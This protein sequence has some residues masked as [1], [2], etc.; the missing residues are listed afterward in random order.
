MVESNV[1][2]LS[3]GWS[4]GAGC[5]EVVGGGALGEGRRQS[6]LGLI[7]KRAVAMETA[8]IVVQSRWLL[9]SG[10]CSHEQVRQYPVTVGD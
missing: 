5:G 10:S 4:G 7:L 2:A 6:S 8:S 3:L 9:Q 1:D